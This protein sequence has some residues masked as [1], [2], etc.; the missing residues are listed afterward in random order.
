MSDDINPDSTYYFT[1]LVNGV[2][3]TL[4]VAWISEEL[5]KAFEL[6]ENAE[7]GH[8]RIN[9][10]VGEHSFMCCVD[11]PVYLISFDNDDVFKYAGD[12]NTLEL[13]PSGNLPEDPEM[14]TV[15]DFPTYFNIGVAPLIDFRMG[16]QF[17]QQ[18]NGIWIPIEL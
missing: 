16:N 15:I 4:F 9:V 17:C 8:V 5:I 10:N 11:R 7:H 1:C 13:Y 12:D 3:Q 2:Y 14:L 6:L 18:V